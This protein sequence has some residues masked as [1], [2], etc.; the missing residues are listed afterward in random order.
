MILHVLGITFLGHG[1][2]WKLTTEYKAS[3][4]HRRFF[5]CGDHFRPILL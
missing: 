3:L 1:T 4:R 5:N 2:L